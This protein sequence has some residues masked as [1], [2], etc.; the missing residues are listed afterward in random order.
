MGNIVNTVLVP[1]TSAEHD[2][3]NSHIGESDVTEVTIP[4]AVHVCVRLLLHEQTSPSARVL[5]GVFDHELQ[6]SLEFI[7]LTRA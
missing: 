1:T 2:D 7:D 3:L 6:V 4:L 5:N